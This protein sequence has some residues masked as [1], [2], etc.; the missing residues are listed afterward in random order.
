MPFLLETNTKGAAEFVNGG[1]WADFKR[2]LLERRPPAPDALDEP[3]V[4]AAKGHQ[5]AAFERCIDE[6]EKLPFE[7]APPEPGA[8]FDRP[9][10][11]ITED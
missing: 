1:L 7:F 3:H 4:A 8:A 10:V 9:A 6:I 11:N 2:A 5:R